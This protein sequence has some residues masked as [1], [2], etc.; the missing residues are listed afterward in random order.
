[1]RKTVGAAAPRYRDSASPAILSRQP[2][3]LTADAGGTCLIDAEAAAFVPRH[4]PIGFWRR[5]QREPAVAQSRGDAVVLIAGAQIRG[6]AVGTGLGEVALKLLRLFGEQ[7]GDFTAMGLL[8]VFGD[9]G[10]AQGKDQTDDRNHDHD[11][12][13]G[14]PLFGSAHGQESRLLNLSP[15]DAPAATVVFVHPGADAA[16]GIADDLASAMGVR[17]RSVEHLTAERLQLDQFPTTSV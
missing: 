17:N 2:V 16:T 11:F 12:D 13:Q 3:G 4:H 10:K 8:H 15:Q 14:E 1:M 9:A 7:H 5:G 6:V